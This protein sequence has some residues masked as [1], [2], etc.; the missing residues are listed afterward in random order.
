[1]NNCMFNVGQTVWCLLY[2]KGK[3]V[4]VESQDAYPITVE[5]DNAD[6]QRYTYDGKYH[7]YC[8]RTLFFSEPK[9]EAQEFPS[10][11]VGKTV[12]AVSKY[13]PDDI[14]GPGI[15][16]DEHKDYISVDGYALSKYHYNFYIV[17]SEEVDE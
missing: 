3:V 2:G 13:N 10:K 5:F 7:V 17:E 16:R 14:F 8:P 11:Y 4:Q 15:V 1:M 12:F 9:I 6:N